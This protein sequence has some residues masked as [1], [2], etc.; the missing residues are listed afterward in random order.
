MVLCIRS[1]KLSYRLEVD[2]HVLHV[3]I[4]IFLFNLE[5]LKSISVKELASFSYLDMRNELHSSTPFKWCI[6]QGLSIVFFFA[7]LENLAKQLR[8]ERVNHG[9]LL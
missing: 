5:V 2:L 4:S 1:C 3:P 6:T 7:V 9:Q 8:L